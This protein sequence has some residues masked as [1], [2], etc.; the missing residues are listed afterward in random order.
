MYRMDSIQ[1][2]S[3]LFGFSV[4]VFFFLLA[5]IIAIQYIKTYRQELIISV[6]KQDQ[7][8]NIIHYSTLLSLRS[9]D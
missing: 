5:F 8:S 3:A 1:H 9:A 4:L 2:N 6:I 7:I